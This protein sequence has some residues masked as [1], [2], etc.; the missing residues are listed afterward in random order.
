MPGDGFGANV[1]PKI[2]DP[3]SGI[4]SHKTK[5]ICFVLETEFTQGV[6]G[7]AV[8]VRFTCPVDSSVELG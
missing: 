7:H 8:S 2:S 6:I 3:D 4:P 1:N 5:M